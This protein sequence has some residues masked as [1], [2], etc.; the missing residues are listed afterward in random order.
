METAKL[1][2]VR[3]NAYVTLQGS[4]SMPGLQDPILH[5]FKKVPKKGNMLKSSLEGVETKSRNP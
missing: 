4:L 2:S 5:F 3:D 1:C